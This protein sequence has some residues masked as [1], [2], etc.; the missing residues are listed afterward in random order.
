MT[1]TARSNAL[2]SALLSAGAVFLL[3]AG[4][5]SAQSDCTPVSKFETLEP[6]VLKIVAP[7][8][9]PFFTYKDGVMGGF[10]GLFFTKFAKDNCLTPSVTVL[11]LGGVVESVRNRLADVGGAGLNPTAER[12]KVVGLTH[13][14][15]YNAA[16]FVGKNPDPE[17]ENYDGKT[18]GTVTGFVF[19]KELE[20]WGK[21]NLKVYDTAD[22]AFADI[23]SGR[24][25]VMLLGALNAFYRISLVPESG[26]SAVEAKPNPVVTSFNKKGRTNVVHTKDNP[27]LTEALNTAIASMRKDGTLAKMLEE[28][29][30]PATVLIPAA[31]AGEN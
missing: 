4:G 8:M 31:E 14:I 5:A 13:P 3:A 15:Y 11:P 6:G 22:A 17:L 24:L 12:G 23:K 26:L 7:D 10:E 1:K 30:L 20:T 9:P 18:I 25:P 21:A 16:V 27:E 2:L 28:V 19:N 29:K